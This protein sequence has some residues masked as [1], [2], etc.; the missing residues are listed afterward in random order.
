MVMAKRMTGLREQILQLLQKKHM[1]S[2]PEL[3]EALEEKF[4][5]I[6]KTT[7]YR[8]LEY[9]LEAGLICQHQFS[10]KEAVY[11]LRTHHHDHVVCTSCGKLKIVEC[12]TNIPEQV[13]GFKVEHHHLTAFG[14]CPDCQKKGLHS[15]T[16][17]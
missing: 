14:I 12:F 1:M 5:T 8:S 3:V 13:E 16:S 2:V 7:V 10:H 11:E 15:I 17:S 9:F 6:N 4:P